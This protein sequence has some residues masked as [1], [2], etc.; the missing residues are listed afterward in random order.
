MFQKLNLLHR[1]HKCPTAFHFIS[2][3]CVLALA[4]LVQVARKCWAHEERSWFSTSY[5]Y[6]PELVYHCFV[7]HVEFNLLVHCRDS[8]YFVRPMLDNLVWNLERL[9]TTERNDFR[10]LEM[11]LGELFSFI[12]W[13]LYPVCV[14]LMMSVVLLMVPAPFSSLTLLW[15]CFHEGQALRVHQI[16]EKKKP[17]V[18]LE[19][20]ICYEES[21]GILECG[22]A[23]C[24][25]DDRQL[26]PRKCPVCRAISPNYIRIRK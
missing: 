14:I 2:L 11:V 18:L 22:H 17:C 3:S 12:L 4:S 25:C 7:I 19:C 20:V 10:K 6:A 23:I 16:E 15:A 21:D 9:K 26:H 1:C 13:I 24:S 8:H 5:S